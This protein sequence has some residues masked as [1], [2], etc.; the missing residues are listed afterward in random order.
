MKNKPIFI[1]S[2][3]PYSIFLEIFFKIFKSKFFSKY[4]KPIIVIAS[5]KL[6]E[7]QMKTMNFS[8]EINLIK[9]NQISKI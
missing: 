6:V 7:L 1:I 9:P 8:F 3:E 4:K 5:K 2:G